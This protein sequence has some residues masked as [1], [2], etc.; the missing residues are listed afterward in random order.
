MVLCCTEFDT[1]L[2]NA[3]EVPVVTGA[4]FNVIIV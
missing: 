2:S 4:K 3:N 1:T